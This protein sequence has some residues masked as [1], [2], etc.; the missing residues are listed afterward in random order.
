MH[1]EHCIC[2]FISSEGKPEGSA[3]RA[4]G[5]QALSVAYDVPN[6]FTEVALTISH[7]SEGM[8][9]PVMVDLGVSVVGGADAQ[10]ELTK[11]SPLRAFSGCT[12]G[13]HM[14]QSC[15][16]SC[17]NADRAVLPKVAQ[18]LKVRHQPSGTAAFESASL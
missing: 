18:T 6:A 3:A 5:R 15:E 8:F 14:M 17:N 1:P 9:V 13:Q 4:S 10:V 12:S 7:A 16:G 11:S 2:E